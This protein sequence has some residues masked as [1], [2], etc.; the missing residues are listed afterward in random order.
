MQTSTFPSVRALD[1]L[2]DGLGAGA[3]RRRQLDMVRGELGRALERG[4]LPVGAR[5]SLQRLLEK[6]ALEPYVRLAESGVLR[7][8]GRGGLPAHVGGDQRDP[9]QV[10]RPAARGAGDARVRR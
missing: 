3:A 7:H 5:R 4:A 9:P 2:L 6:E 1:Q 10:H 8:T